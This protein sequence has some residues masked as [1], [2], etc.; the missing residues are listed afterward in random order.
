MVC[1]TL[2]TTRSV[3]VGILRAGGFADFPSP[4][5]HDLGVW[6]MGFVLASCRAK[7]RPYDCSGKYW[8]RFVNWNRKMVA[9]SA[10]SRD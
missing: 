8:I 1:L 3:Y 2:V 10:G 6:M 5:E 4:S 9:F 7:S